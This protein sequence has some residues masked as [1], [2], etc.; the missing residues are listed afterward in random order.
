MSD[1]LQAV[2]RLDPAPL[3]LDRYVRLRCRR[4]LWSVSG[5]RP[6]AAADVICHTWRCG[7]SNSGDS[8]VGSSS[9]FQ[10]VRIEWSYR[11]VSDSV[12]CPSLVRNAISFASHDPYGVCNELSYRFEI[13]TLGACEYAVQVVLQQQKLRLSG[14]SVHSES[15]I[16]Q[17]RPSLAIVL[18]IHLAESSRKMPFL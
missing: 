1:Q 9:T 5:A 6:R 14:D 12:L 7:G 11:G 8:C 2:V 17:D 18:R 15:S 3:M 13:E 4:K 10:M 16:A